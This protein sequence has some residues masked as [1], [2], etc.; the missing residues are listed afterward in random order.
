MALNF[1][2]SPK[3]K[4]RLKESKRLHLGEEI[5]TAYSSFFV[6]EAH[7]KLAAKVCLSTRIAS[8]K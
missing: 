3:E 5:E 8:S 2:K 4:L 1:D 6:C 7:T